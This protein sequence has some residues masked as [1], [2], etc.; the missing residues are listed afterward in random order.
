MGAVMRVV[1]VFGAGLLIAALVPLPSYNIAF[2]APPATTS[3]YM[4]TVDGP[5]LFNEGCSQG[6]AADS[7]FA[8]LDFGEPWFQ[9]GTYGTI[10]FDGVGSFASTAQIE[11]AVEQFLNG[12]WTCSPT[13]TF[14]RLGIGTSNFHGA[15]STEHGQAWGG[16]VAAVST[17][18]STPPSFASQEAAR[19]ANDLEM[20]W[21]SAAASRAWADGFSGA[22]SLPYY[23]YG[24]CEGC[25]TGGA[26]LG[27]PGAVVNNGWTQEDV[28][29][30]AYGAPSA[31]PVPE[32][33]L[34]SGINAAQWQQLSL[35]GY[36]NHASALFFVGALTQFQACL[37]GG[38]CPGADN[39]PSQ[40]WSQLSN[41][42]N[43]DARTAQTLDW[44]SDIT[45]AN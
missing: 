24:D 36:I 21:N 19:G 43:G 4:A 10:V 25:P 33:Y 6:Q 16:M 9:N 44:V 45:W 1:A 42:L 29:Y 38:G 2:A 30:V 23:D 5:T 41:A 26:V 14:L 8:I 27:V 20:G 31:Y 40:G 32:I 18:I 15:T 12:Y 3:R 34:T 7:G 22:T 39:T 35:Y 37:S 17:W 13:S 28:W 11:A